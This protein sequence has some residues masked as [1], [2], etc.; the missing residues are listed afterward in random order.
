MGK[1]TVTANSI[2]EGVIW[3]QMLLFFFPILLGTFFQQ[4]YNTTDAII[5]GNFVGKEALAA[6]GGT[7][8]TLINLLIGF[9]VGLAGGATVIIAQY[10]GARDHENV[11]LSVHTALALAITGGAVLTFTGIAL[12]GWALRCMGTPE[13]VYPMSR[14]YMMIYFAGTIPNLIYNIGSGILRAVGDSR[15][16]LYFL[17]AACLVNIVLDLIFVA[18]LGMG[19]AGVGLATVLSQ[20][21]SAVLVLIVLLRTRESYR[22]FPKEI[23][24]HKK[25]LG[26]II[27]IGLPAGIQST[28]YSVSN[29]LIQASI[30]SFGTDVM[31]AWTAYGKLDGLLWMTLN[32][33][34]ITVTT[35]SGQNFGA[36]L[37]DRMRKSVRSGM[38]M[39]VAASLGITVLF[40]LFGNWGIR[41]FVN[42]EST[43]AFGMRLLYVMVPGY[44][45]YVPIEILSGACRSAGDSLKPMLITAIGICGLRVIWLLA[46]VP[47]WHELE[48]LAFSYPLTWVITSIFFIIYYLKGNWLKRNLPTVQPEPEP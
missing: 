32:A 30:N 8:G 42:D 46:V 11:H 9:F 36:G 10:F 20:T 26:R 45:T 19:V 47:F 23:R 14:T 35:F 5:V 25:T 13:D 34:G 4:L 48:V 39:A 3:N 17:I 24:F 15:R 37:Y 40:L 41:L 44:V 18:W 6:V 27:R 43:L 38:I 7:S 31:A 16:P 33:F 29:V 12:S 28:M 2:T 22:L 1:R 21:V